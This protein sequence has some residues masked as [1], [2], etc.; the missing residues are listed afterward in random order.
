MQ[1][2]TPLTPTSSETRP[3]P[4]GTQYSSK[5]NVGDARV[6]DE[7]LR[8]SLDREDTATPAEGAA[9]TDAQIKMMR[10]IAT[11]YSNA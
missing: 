6:L 4:E 8:R 5:Q 9:L 11:G 3:L 7:A 10:L 2:S 1:S